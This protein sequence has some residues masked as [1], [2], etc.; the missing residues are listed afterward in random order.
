MN[1]RDIAYLVGFFMA[2]ALCAFWTGCGLDQHL[3]RIEKAVAQTTK[4]CGFPMVVLNKDDGRAV[5]VISGRS[6]DGG[7]RA[8]VQPM[9]RLLDGGWTP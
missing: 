4:T 3:D 2:L 9:Y 6:A 1:D 7:M 5:N 8:L